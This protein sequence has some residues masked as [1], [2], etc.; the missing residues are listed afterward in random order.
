MTDDN[1]TSP[2]KGA[3][4]DEDGREMLVQWTDVRGRRVL[5]LVPQFDLSDLDEGEQRLYWGLRDMLEPTQARENA[6]V[7]GD[8]FNTLVEPG[9][10]VT[11][12]E[13]T[14]RVHEQAVEFAEKLNSAM[15]SMAE[16]LAPAIND[17]AEAL[18]P[19]SNA[20]ANGE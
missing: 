15:G 13:F 1:T 12:R 10:T 8:P 17:L 19:L 4:N 11:L 18:E 14:R 3:W 9:E 20:E 16:L 5:T 2:A 7:L 6:L